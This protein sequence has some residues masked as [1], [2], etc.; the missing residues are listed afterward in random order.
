MFLSR[1]DLILVSWLAFRAAMDVIF[2][3]MKLLENRK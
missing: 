1:T 2:I 3:V